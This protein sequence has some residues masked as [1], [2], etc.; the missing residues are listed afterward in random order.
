MVTVCSGGRV[1]ICS[2]RVGSRRYLD[3]APVTRGGGRLVRQVGA[4]AGA[5]CPVVLTSSL[6]RVEK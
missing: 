5:A 4:R 2:D 6:Q 1:T 3:S